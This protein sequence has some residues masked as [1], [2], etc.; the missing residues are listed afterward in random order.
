MTRGQADQVLPIITAF[1]NGKTVQKSIVSRNEWIDDNSPTFS[2]EFDW[3]IKPQPRIVPFDFND[4]PIFIN[5]VVKIKNDPTI[6]AVVAANQSFIWIGV[7]PQGY[8][9]TEFFN[10]FTFVDGSPC[11]KKID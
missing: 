5:K 2:I 10:N 6:Y 7:I 1:I 9:Y 4:F 11:G 8:S 3:R